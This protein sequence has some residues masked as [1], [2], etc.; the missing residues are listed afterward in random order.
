M[1]RATPRIHGTILLQPGQQT[2]L[3]EVGSPAW[4]AWLEAATTFAFTDAAGSFTARKERSGRSGAYWKA[5]RMRD[6]MLRRVYLGKSSDL[7]LVRLQAAAQE[8]AE[9]APGIGTSRVDQDLPQHDHTAGSQSPMLGALLLAAKLSIPQAPAEAIVRAQLV[10]RLNLG[11]R[12]RLTLLSAPA[13]FGKTTLLSAWLHG[14]AD[15]RLQIADLPHSTP[16][17]P[18]PNPQPPALA[19]VSLDAEDN[20]PVRFWSYIIGALAGV[21]PGVGAVAMIA[22]SADQG[23]IS[24]MLTGLLNTLSLLTYETLLVLDDYHLIDATPIHQA[25]AFFIERLPRQLHLVIATRCDPPLPLTR[26]RARGELTELRRP[27]LRFTLDET[28]AF[29]IERRGLALTTDDVGTLHMRTEGWAAGL[30]L[31]TVAARDSSNLAAFVA[32]FSGSSRIVME[33]LVDEVL[34]H[35]PAH[36]QDVVLRTSILDRMCD[37]LCEAVMDE[38]RR[39]NDESTTPLVVRP[40]SSVFGELERAN[41]L[42]SLPED[43]RTW[44]RYPQLLVE[45]ARE[46]LRATTSAGDVATLHAAASAWYAQH[47][48]EGQ[49]YRCE[50]IRHALLARDWERSAQLIEQHGLLLTT[51]G[52]P[53]TVCG[54]LEALPAG[55]IRTRPILCV[56]YAIALMFL[57]RLDAVE[58]RLHDAEHA[59]GP[60]TPHDHALAVLGQIALARANLARCL[61][62]LDRCIALSRQVLLLATTTPVIAHAG[63]MLNLARAYQLSGDAGPAAEQLAEEAITLMRAAGN[64]AGTFASIVNLAQLRM[65]Q[66]QRRLATQIYAQAAQ[67][68][69][70]LDDGLVLVGDAAYYVGVGDL[71]REQN[72][73][74]AAEEHLRRGMDRVAGVQMV[75]ADVVALGYLARARLQQARGDGAGALATLEAF[76]QLARQCAFVPRLHQRGAALRAQLALRH[77]DLSAAVRWADSSGL[78]CTH[79]VHY[80]DEPAYLTLARVYIAMGR[81]DSTSSPSQV[82]LEL[83][84]RLL[85]AAEAGAR[86]ESIIEILVVRALAMQA[87]DNLSSALVSLARALLLA[88]PEGYIRVFVDEGA[89]VIELLRAAHARGIAPAYVEQLLAAFPNDGL[90]IPDCTLAPKQSPISNLHSAMLEAL[91]T[92]ELEVVRLMAEGASNRTI[93]ERLTLSVGTVKRYANNIFSKLDVQSRTQAIVKAR[94]LRLL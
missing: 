63:A 72:D 65:R 2:D 81:A 15:C 87:L 54:W 27:D 10:D 26:L 79:S 60:D 85:V 50:A 41:L 44:Y 8:L 82:A 19:W 22:R 66:G 12:G 36:V 33:Y 39:T 47:V 83:L 88:A 90:H 43:Q 16:Q 6:R 17:P 32:T 24:A 74:D 73:L 57:G 67:S 70:A 14:I 59:I 49:L 62:D 46:R 40:S 92:R 48:Q 51:G 7:T 89:P 30:Q 52:L 5:Y 29:L 45:A 9:R 53:Q 13:G 91:T 56:Y 18:T 4:F 69:A 37:A 86:A 78:D 3:I 31:A 23:S 20:D 38:G 1:A 71:L 93:A 84:N 75:D 21:C 68:I 76:A 61:G 58:A 25:L 80:P 94:A 77:G 34:N 28:S 11:L 35:L 64:R 55:L 42:I